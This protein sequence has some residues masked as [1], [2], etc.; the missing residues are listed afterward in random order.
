[1]NV[2]HSAWSDSG[3]LPNPSVLDG[4]AADEGTGRM[5]FEISELSEV[6]ELC[7]A[8]GVGSVR[9]SNVW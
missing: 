7:I 3:Q 4:N 1:M 8:F 9:R 5:G 6:E 2:G